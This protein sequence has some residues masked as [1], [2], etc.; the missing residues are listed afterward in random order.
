[1]HV[2]IE[3]LE[4]LER[5][6]VFGIP[7]QR[8][9]D[10]VQ[11]RIREL[12]GHVRLN[13][14]RQGKVPVAV[15]DKQL[16]P[17]VRQEVIGDLL[18]ASFYEAAA[19]E[20]LKLASRPQ[21]AWKPAEP[22]APP[23]FEAVFEVYP[24]FELAPVEAIRIERPIAEVGETDV[25]AMLA[26]LQ[27]LHLAWHPVDRPARIGDRLIVDM[28]GHMDDE[29]L[30]EIRQIPFILGQPAQAEIFGR[31]VQDEFL[32][33]LEGVSPGHF[34]DME[35]GFPEEYPK[36]HLAGQNVR[37]TLHLRSVAEPRLPDLDDALAEKLGIN[38]GLNALRG[39]TRS[40][41]AEAL[42]QGQRES[43]KAQ[44]MDA[45]LA[46]NPLELPKARVESES[47]RMLEAVKARMKAD[48]LDE[49]DAEIAALLVEEQARRR[50]G[51]GLI[52]AKLVRDH[53]LNVPKESLE[54]MLAQ[55]AVGQP[56]EAQT[57]LRQDIDWVAEL[58]SSALEEQLVD[59]VLERAEV[60]DKPVSFA[61]F[62]Q[63]RLKD[64]LLA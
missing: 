19:K 21:I 25:D 42:R 49:Q 63:G 17:Q 15:V 27:R 47:A 16:G 39:Q 5:R 34:V 31:L 1:M 4:G 23:E 46:A 35:I 55:L 33:Q 20:K 56:E 2:I 10:A 53:G 61:G 40:L 62:M 22:E 37:F 3:S 9:Y 38:G 28:Q 44:V 45:L 43:V 13:G 18:L 50:I 64:G 8:I 36:D 60:V 14:F 52:L 6:M 54:A 41:M 58:E 24:E 12:A 11:Q 59:W 51:L 48:G 30:R 26:A 57:W 7:E 32:R 29:P